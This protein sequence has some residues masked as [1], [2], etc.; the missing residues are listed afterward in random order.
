[1]PGAGGVGMMRPFIG[2]GVPVPPIALPPP[3]KNMRWFQ[4]PGEVRGG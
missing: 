4:V 3:P 2:A 1:M